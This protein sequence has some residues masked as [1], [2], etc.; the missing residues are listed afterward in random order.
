MDSAST[1]AVALLAGIQGSMPQKATS[2]N[3]VASTRPDTAV[4]L[5]CAV[6]TWFMLVGTATTLAVTA[7]ADPH[8]GLPGCESPRHIEDVSAPGVMCRGK[9]GQ[10][11]LAFR[12]RITSTTF[13]RFMNLTSDMVR[14]LDL[15]PDSLARVVHTDRRSVQVAVGEQTNLTSTA[16]RSP[17]QC[18]PTF[19]CEMRLRDGAG[20]VWPMTYEATTSSNQYHR[21]LAQGWRE[22]CRHHEVRVG[23]AVDFRRRLPGEGVDL[24]VKV[25]RRR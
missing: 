14:H 19:Q 9:R 8:G 7:P 12:R 10:K 13:L 5:V 1:N 25:V 4:S 16:C 3:A 22:F 18:H 23:D 24:T 20:R 2:L 6:D 21:R 11:R 17:S 15:D